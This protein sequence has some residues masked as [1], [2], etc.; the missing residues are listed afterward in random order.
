MYWYDF[1]RNDVYVGSGGKFKKHD[2]KAI[3]YEEKEKIAAFFSQHLLKIYYSD[4]SSYD[5]SDDER[6]SD[7]YYSHSSYVYR[8]VNIEQDLYGVAMRGEEITGV[9]FYV[10]NSRGD[11]YATVFNFDGKPRASIT[12]G[13]SASH[14][15]SYTTVCRVELV[16]KG[17]NGAPESANKA[18]FIQHEMYPNI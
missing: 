8:E 13:Y 2:C 15:S 3:S 18:S 16:K 17:E 11:A 6:A 12:M 4:S 7:S 1:G 5:N 10:K 9:V 14:S